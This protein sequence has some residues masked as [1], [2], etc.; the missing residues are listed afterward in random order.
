MK[1]LGVFF[2]A[3][4][5]GALVVGPMTSAG[6]SHAD[7]TYELPV[8]F[9]WE[10]SALDVVV[11][12]PNHGQIF[13]GN[14]ALNGGDPN[15]LTPFNTYLEAV[16]ASIA[17][18]DTA[19]EMF[20]AEWLQEGLVTNVYVAGRDPIPPGVLG[21][22]EILIVSDET[23][24]TIL[25]VAVSTRPCLVDNSKFFVQSFTYED[26]YNINAQEYGHCL[27]LEHVVDNHPELDAMA[28]L[29]IHNPGAKG[30]PLHCPSNL[31]VI[32]LEA[33]FGRLFQKPSPSSVSI[34]IAAYGTVCDPPTGALPD[35]STSPQPGSTT[36]PGPQPSTSASPQPSMSASPS[37]SPSA[38]ST[39]SPQPSSAP[40]HRH[41]RTIDLR[42]VRHV[43]ARGEVATSD[44]SEECQSH[45]RVQI[46]RKTRGGWRMIA[47]VATM[48]DGSFRRNLPDREGRYRA[49][50]AESSSGPH[51]CDRAVSEVRF[52][53]H[54]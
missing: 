31:D 36:A 26:M 34:P 25:G 4:V 9:R 35:F 28:G 27:G 43:K 16:E 23:K 29:Y 11:V 1:R 38:S 6:A 18:W 20:G 10:K 51:I 54:R 32:G 46:E 5:L 14:G 33:V 37:P 13:N 2:A 40:S 30:N 44:G 12:P 53:N 22:P 19:V 39:P 52:H 17:D 15:E 45:V 47:T 7:G 8:W 42:I 24:A 3:L 49:R 41:P 50:V 48:S 21:D